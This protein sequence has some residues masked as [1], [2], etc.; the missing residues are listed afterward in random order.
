VNRR[1]FLKGVAATAAVLAAPAPLGAPVH[2]V[3]PPAHPLALVAHHT[4][5]YDLMKHQVAF[6]YAEPG[7]SRALWWAD[8]VDAYTPEVEATLRPRAESAF[9]RALA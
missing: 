9:R 7:T 6:F 3:A 5:R 8:L 2:V 1:D 4:W